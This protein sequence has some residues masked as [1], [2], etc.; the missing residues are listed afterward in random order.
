H[1]ARVAGLRL[2]RIHEDHEEDP[3]TPRSE[4]GPEAG[5]G[6]IIY[7]PRISHPLAGRV[8]CQAWSK[9]QGSG[10]CLVGVRRFKSCPTHPSREPARRPEMRIPEEPGRSPN[11]PFCTA[12]I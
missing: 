10:S 11:G 12:I 1:G 8:G 2:R 4:G 3:V 9:A 6:K 7:A 5:T